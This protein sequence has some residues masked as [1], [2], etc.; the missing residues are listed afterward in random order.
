MNCSCGEEQLL[1]LWEKWQ[2]KN[3]D[4]KPS[5]IDFDWADLISAADEKQLLHDAALFEKEHNNG[6]W[7]SYW[8]LKAGF[9]SKDA[10]ARFFT[11]E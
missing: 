8:D 2:E 3:L 1:D 11:H 5:E 6:Q 4:S 9:S 7:I 10:P